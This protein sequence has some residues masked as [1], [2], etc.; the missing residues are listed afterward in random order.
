MIESASGKTDYGLAVD[1]PVLEWD[2]VH[3]VDESQFTPPHTPACQR[4]GQAGQA[5]GSQCATLVV[6]RTALYQCDEAIEVTVND[7]KQAGAQ[8][9][10]VQAATET[11]SVQITTGVNRVNTPIKSFPL[12][13]VSPGLFRGTITVT[14]QFN[15]PGTLFVTPSADQNLTV[16]YIDPLCDADADGQAGERGFD[17]LD[18]DGIAAPPL[19][20]DN[21]PLVYNPAQADSDRTCSGGPTSGKVCLVTGDCGTGGTCVPSPD[22]LGD[23]CDNCPG[24]PNPTQL[25]SDA[26]G[27]GDACDFDDVDFDGVS[28]QLDDCPNVYDPLQIPT[29]TQNPQGIACSGSADRDGDL[30]QDKNDNCVRT[31]NPTQDN[32]D[33]DKLGDACDVDCQGAAMVT[34]AIGS[35]NRSSDIV[36]TT[37]AQCPISG[38]CSLTPSTVCTTNPNCSGAGNTCVILGQEVCVRTGVTNTGNCSPI[39][40]DEDVDKVP[41]AVDDCP[42]IYNPAVLVGTNRQ[43]DTDSDGLGDEC[44]PVGSWDDDN[45]GVPDDLLSYNMAIECR[46]LPLAKLVVKSI[47]AGDTNGD[48]DIFPD[49]GETARIYL[50]VQNAGTFDLTNVYLN[51]NSTDPDIACITKPSIF[52]ALFRAGETLVLGTPGPDKIAG[53][54]DDTG[55]YFELVTKTTMQS[56]SGSNPAALDMVLTLTSAESLGTSST[57]PI[58]VLADL[59]IPPG[60]TQVKTPGPDGVSGNSDDGWV[61]ETFDQ[62][63]NGNFSFGLADQPYGTPNVDNDTIGV[64]VRTTAGGLGGLAVVACG[65]FNVPPADAGC[66][67]DPDND[68]DWHLH[69]PAAAPTTNCSATNLCCPNTGHHLTPVND[70]MAHS[71]SNSLHWGYHFDLAD[72]LKDTTRFRQIAAFM[73][74]PINLALFPE[75]TDLE[76]SFYQ[77]AQMMSNDEP[78]LNAKPGNAFDYGDVQIQLDQDP[79]PATDNWGVWDKL[80]PFQN[81]YD[82][83]PQIWSD[84]GTSRMNRFSTL[85]QKGS[86]SRSRL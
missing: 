22:G 48:H 58:H 29:S 17:N 45:N 69:C 72:R 34:L 47:Q 67:I 78:T 85:L 77:I 18:G 21:C 33:H 3:P 86:R 5:A 49:S 80:V 7:P 46:T 68:M 32:T 27:V 76:L 26:D 60:A 50:T 1:D 28:N 63:L 42:A 31:Y 71:G 24:T 51:L 81:V 82:H 2:E 53:N 35:C 64:T 84:F 52:R 16:Y 61:I 6:D 15:N 23:F 79:N 39:D 56:T 4:F 66:I 75:A 8:F 25:D 73:T 38:V 37:D 43:R 70:S 20:T 44:D 14:G 54:A 19:G 36:C 40:D 12:P 57:V 62:D 74:R 83:I 65:G 41:D 30:I 13:A 55:D 59:D 11:D 9:V 10:T